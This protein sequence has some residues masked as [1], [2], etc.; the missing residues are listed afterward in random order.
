MIT[1][2]MPVKQIKPSVPAA[3]FAQA[4]PRCRFCDAELA[5]TL[6]DLGT[7]PLCQRQVT[8]E[9]YNHPEPFYPLHVRVCDRCMLVQL[10]EYVSANEIFGQNDYA[11][12][13]SYSDTQVEHARVYAEMAA[14][15]F[16]VARGKRV[17][18][19]ASND[20]YLLQHF[21]AKGV[22]VLGIEPAGNVAKA[23]VAKGIPTEVKFFGRKTAYD[24]VDG[25]GAADLIVCNNVVPH[26]PDIND[27][28][29]GLKVLLGERGVV[30]IEFQHC[31]RMM[32]LNQFDTI[33]HEHFS[34]LTLTVT[35]RIFAHHGLAVFDVEELPTHGGSLRVYARH[36]EDDARPVEPRVA[37]MKQFEADRGLNDLRTYAAW[38]E[39]VK[40][41]KR[42]LLS[43]LAEARRAG[44]TV[45]AYG[46]PGK[47]ATLLNYCGIRTDF[48]DYAVDRSP[49]K[50][51][52]FTP[53]TRIPIHH[54]DKVA[55]TRPDYL[56]IL[57][58]NLKDEVMRQMAHIR[59]W[60]GKFVVPIPEVKVID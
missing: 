22:D 34:Y 28:V 27:F 1:Q 9:R 53:G 47:S 15:R 42:K 59:E 32:E 35:E 14:K 13:S 21:V 45:A 4:N 60:G 19:V 30:T 58:W 24:V 44:K 26:V 12:F 51:G 7:S 29:G 23:A 56:L 2:T 48:I 31:A 25:W 46:A 17:V 40:E 6:V 55:E 16:G 38:G 43:F 5:H 36:A 37:A 41:T 20:G 52:T 49:S 39:R 10:P 54:P 50:Y 18:E 57:V 3:R 11:Y 33:Y 8:P